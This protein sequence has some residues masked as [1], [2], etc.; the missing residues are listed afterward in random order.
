[1]LWG[2]KAISAALCSAQKL[3]DPQAQMAYIRRMLHCSKTNCDAPD[4]IRSVPPDHTGDQLHDDQGKD[5]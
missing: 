2:V 3:V 4:G 5:D 1:V